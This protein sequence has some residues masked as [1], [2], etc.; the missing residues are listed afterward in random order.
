MSINLVN[1]STLPTLYFHDDE[2]RSLQM[3]QR[4]SPAAPTWGGEGLLQ[5]LRSYAHLL[6]STLQPTLFLVDPTRA[7]IEAHSTPMF[8]DAAV[9][10]IFSQ[11]SSSPIPPL[12]RP[13]PPSSLPARYP[14]SAP[15]GSSPGQQQRNDRRSS[16]L[17]QGFPSSSRPSSS[18][19]PAGPSAKQA[20]LQS[21]SQLT[22]ATRHAAQ[23]ILSHPLAKPIIPHLPDPV[24]SLVNVQGEWSSWV[25]KGGV[26]EFESARVYLAKWARVSS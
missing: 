15:V 14:P 19:S 8:D 6:R 1:G 12:R 25:E 9:D 18:Q 23:N 11:S 10:L 17:H 21:F 22:R 3:E 26:G 24:K 13:H 16:V 5:R 4:A 2:S 20:L 7:D